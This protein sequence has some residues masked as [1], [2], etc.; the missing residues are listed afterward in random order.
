MKM[1]RWKKMSN[2]KLI[3]EGITDWIVNLIVNNRVR[4]AERA[5]SND[6]LLQQRFKDFRIA[7]DKLQKTWEEI[8]EKRKGTNLD[9][10]DVM[11]EKLEFD[12]DYYSK[13]GKDFRDYL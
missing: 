4:E 12:R 6:R 7:Q 8:C 13:R 11:R 3:S 5:F 10:E 2:K 9:C 1:K